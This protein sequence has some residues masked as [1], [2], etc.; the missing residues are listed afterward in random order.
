MK[1]FFVSATPIYS[2][3]FSLIFNNEISIWYLILFLHFSNDAY[4][5]MTGYRLRT[6][7]FLLY[8]FF[9]FSYSAPFES[10]PIN[11]LSLL[12]LQCFL[13]CCCF[14]C[15]C[16]CYL[17]SSLPSEFNRSMN[18]NKKTHELSTKI[19]R[20]RLFSTYRPV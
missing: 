13:F 16:Y 19:Q 15:R 3:N 18:E 17:P 1:P 10:V 8:F 11:S 4:T 20:R 12:F 5:F 9:F 2:T 6:S 14:R 7:I